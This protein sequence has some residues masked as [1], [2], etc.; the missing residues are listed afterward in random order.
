MVTG[1]RGQLPC[2]RERTGGADTI[3]S[4][5]DRRK[6]GSKHHLT[7]DGRGT[8]L[9]VIT[10]T[11]NVNDATQTLALIDSSP[12]VAG[13]PD[14]P[15]RHPEALLEDKSYDCDPNREELHKRRILPG[16]PRNGAANTK[17][18]GKLRYAVK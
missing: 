15:R 11:P 8:P 16:S 12:P 9:K 17:D 7:C 1:L 10:T 3:P 6:T 18:M 2:P 4:P 14:Q 13:H 5:V